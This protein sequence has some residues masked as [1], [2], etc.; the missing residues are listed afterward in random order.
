M[1]YLRRR[2]PFSFNPEL[3]ARIK[4]AASAA[5]LSVTSWLARCAEDRL[6]NDDG[7]LAMQEYELLFGPFPAAAL[8]RADAELDEAFDT[9]QV[10]TRVLRHGA[11]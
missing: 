5:G 1:A 9:A 6:I 2:T 7:L 4:S 8:E 10:A 11:V 3:D